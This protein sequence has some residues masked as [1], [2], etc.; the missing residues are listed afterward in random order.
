M[1]QMGPRPYIGR[2]MGKPGARVKAKVGA[3]AC[4]VAKSTPDGAGRKIA[5]ARKPAFG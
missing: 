4:M 1:P 2:T 3:G 5:L